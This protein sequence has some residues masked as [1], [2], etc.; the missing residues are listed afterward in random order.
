MYKQVESGSMTVG[1][2]KEA[3]A[4]RTGV[5]VASQIL[6]HGGKSLTGMFGGGGNTQRL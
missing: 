4:G 1:S 6:V 3:L 5:P 2:L